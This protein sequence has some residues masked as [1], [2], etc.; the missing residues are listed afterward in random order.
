M[1]QA[2]SYAHAAFIIEST[3]LAL[4]PQA[5][6]NESNIQVACVKLPVAPIFVL[7][8]SQLLHVLVRDACMLFDSLATYTLITGPQYISNIPIWWIQ[9]PQALRPL[10]APSCIRLTTPLISDVCL[11]ELR[12]AF[13]FPARVG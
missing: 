11:I 13:G 2:A 6:S 3:I 9:L 7:H 4:V 8:L 1:H 5:V 10:A 12:P